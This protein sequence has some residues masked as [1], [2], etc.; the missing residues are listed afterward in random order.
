MVVERRDVIV[1]A[2]KVVLALALAA[3][4]L[5]AVGVAIVWPPESPALPAVVIVLAVSSLLLVLVEREGWARLP[6]SRALAFVVLDG[7]G[8]LALLVILPPDLSGRGLV[9]GGFVVLALLHLALAW[10]LRERSWSGMGNLALSLGSLL[11]T[12]LLVEWLIAPLAYRMLTTT[13]PQERAAAAEATPEAAPLEEAPSEN[14]PAPVYTPTDAAAEVP[15]TPEPAP[16]TIPTWQTE[17]IGVAGPGPGWGPLTGWGTNTDTVLHSWMDGY[18]DVNVAFNSLGFRGPAILYE[19]PDEVYRILIVG[20]SFVE[21][22]QV[23]YADTIYAQLATM[24]ADTHR[25]DGRRV[26]VFGVGATGWGTLQAYLY[27]HHE[28]MRFDPD[29]IVH[30]FYINDVVDN[31]PTVFYSD[32][33][34]SSYDFVIEGDSVRAVNLNEQP[35]V[36]PGEFA[37]PPINPVKRLLDALPQFLQ[38]TATVGVIRLWADPPRLIASLGGNLTQ[39]HPQTYIFVQEPEI[40]GYREGWYRTQ[41]AYEIWAA[42]AQANGAQLMV[43]ALDVPPER[44]QMMANFWPE[45]TADWVWDDELPY[46]RLGVILDSVDVPLVL[47][48]EAYRD[49]AESVGQPVMDAIFIPYDGHWTPAGHRVSAEVLRDAL[50]EQGIVTLEGD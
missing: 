17:V 29:L 38:D 16:A 47:T 22:L 35:G 1:I 44:V 49:Y 26:E 37:P 27:Y 18:F 15:P 19:K 9:I 42:E 10:S 40:D 33:F 3:G 43:L 6:V 23:D 28:G 36:S 46:T 21:A 12:L 34:R 48:R 8:A 31:N 4:Y 45:E 7:I 14:T 24:L 13:A 11:V 41:R 20:D 50:V 25:S 2:V 39:T 30:V 32:P 5:W